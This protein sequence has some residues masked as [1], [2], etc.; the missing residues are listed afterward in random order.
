[1]PGSRVRKM[2]QKLVEEALLKDGV[3]QVKV[4]SLEW[5]YV[6]TMVEN[7]DFKRID[8]DGLYV[9]YRLVNRVT[10]VA[11]NKEGNHE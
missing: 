3:I 7:G 10:G 2:K 5:R 8:S 4:K 11:G 9:T 1:M 6:E